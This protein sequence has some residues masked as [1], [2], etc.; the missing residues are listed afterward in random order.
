MVAREEWPAGHIDT[1]R[2][3][4]ASYTGSEIAERLTAAG[5]PCT[6][7]SVIGK[8]HR[9]GLPGKKRS[10]GR[11]PTIWNAEA[12]RIIRARWG[13]GC[14]GAEITREVWD[15][16]ALKVTP[17]TVSAKAHAMGLPRNPRPF[18]APRVRPVPTSRPR[19]PTMTEVVMMA[20]AEPRLVSTLNLK[21]DDCRFPIG[22]PRQPGFGFCGATKWDRSRSY[23]EYHHRL[24][25][26]PPEKR[27]NRVREAVA[28]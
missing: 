26:R 13:S 10:T 22:D 12:E 7:N 15:R 9:L 27:E 20:A 8:A 3:M 4:W 25:W 21:P 17:K 18:S 28:A 24:C 5:F 6:R 23:C 16:A 1:L 2:R 11:P 14:S 19:L